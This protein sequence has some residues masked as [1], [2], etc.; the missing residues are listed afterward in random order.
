MQ[1]VG[2]MPSCTARPCTDGLPLA[3]DRASNNCSSITFKEHGGFF[4]GGF[5]FLGG[6]G[7]VFGDGDFFGWGE[8]G[9]DG[10]QVQVHIYS[11]IFLLRSLRRLLF[12]V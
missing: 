8:W 9:M 12:F 10:M 6:F 1:L 5:D 11:L 2:E 4:L 3:S 7:K